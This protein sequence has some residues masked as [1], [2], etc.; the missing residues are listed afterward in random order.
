MLNGNLK[1]DKWEFEGDEV[2]Q[3]GSK[4][5]TEQKSHIEDI[6]REKEKRKEFNKQ[7]HLDQ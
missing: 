6:I 5:F 3:S 2:F 7:V 4:Q 1:V